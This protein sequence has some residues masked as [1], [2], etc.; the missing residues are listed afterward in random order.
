[1]RG[2]TP[3]LIARFAPDKDGK[4]SFVSTEDGRRHYKVEFALEETPPDV[5]AATFELHP[6]YYD[7]VRTVR[8][9]P[10]GKVALQTTAYGDYDLKVR[11]RTK[12][13]VQVVNANL[14]EALKRGESAESDQPGVLEA[15]S[16]LADH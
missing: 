12:E 2:K 14:V 11:L 16:Y 5:Y 7:P 1:M 10:D 8:P 9:E 6:T 3:K 13:G 15:L 4:P